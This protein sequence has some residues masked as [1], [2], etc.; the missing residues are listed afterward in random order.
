MYLIKIVSI[1][2]KN[3]HCTSLVKGSAPVIVVGVLSQLLLLAWA[4]PWVGRIGML[5]LE[6]DYGHGRVGMLKLEGDY[7]HFLLWKLKNG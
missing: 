6:G 2:Q 3:A 4:I 1:S 5:K 7:G